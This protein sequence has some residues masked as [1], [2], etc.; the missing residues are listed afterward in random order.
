[1]DVLRLLAAKR[2]RVWVLSR[3]GLTGFDNVIS[4]GGNKVGLTVAPEDLVFMEEAKAG[5]PAPKAK[6]SAA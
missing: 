1:V 2:E 6:A 4:V 3:A 5:Q